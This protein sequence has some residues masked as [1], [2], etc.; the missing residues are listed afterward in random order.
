MTLSVALPISTQHA[1]PY[2]NEPSRLPSLVVRSAKPFNA[3]TPPELLAD[4]LITPNDLFYVRNHLPVPH[5]DAATH[6]VTMY[7]CCGFGQHARPP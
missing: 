4:S 7:A 1:D 6:T 3:E 2:S 5:L